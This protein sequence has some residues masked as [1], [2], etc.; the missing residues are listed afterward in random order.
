ME[1]KRGSSFLNLQNYL[2]HQATAHNLDKNK[3]KFKK[4]KLSSPCGAVKINLTSVL[5]I[6]V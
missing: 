5:R 6:Q 1:M 4:Q 2:T 3:N